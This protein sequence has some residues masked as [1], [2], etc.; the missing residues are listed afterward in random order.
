[1]KQKHH[2]AMKSKKQMKLLPIPTH[3]PDEEGVNTGNVL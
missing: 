1:M 2:T 3:Y